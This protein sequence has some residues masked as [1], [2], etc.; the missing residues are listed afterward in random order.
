MEA[1]AASERDRPREQLHCELHIAEIQGVYYS[2]L[3]RIWMFIHNFPNIFGLATRHATTDDAEP[4]GTEISQSESGSSELGI[5]PPERTTR[6]ETD[7][8]KPHWRTIEPG[9]EHPLPVG[10]GILTAT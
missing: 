3:C 8:P 6:V 1:T 4:T 9:V 5:I 2:A 10:V 7:P